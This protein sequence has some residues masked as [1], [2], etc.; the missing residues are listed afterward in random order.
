MRRRGEDLMIVMERVCAGIINK[1]LE[2][3]EGTKGGTPAVCVKGRGRGLCDELVAALRHS[4]SD[5]KTGIDLSEKLVQELL[6]I[7]SPGRLPIHRTGLE[8]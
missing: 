1:G 2:E 8:P 7:M 5:R 6:T 4:C 3:K